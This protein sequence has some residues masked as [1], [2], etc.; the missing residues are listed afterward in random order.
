MKSLI[1]TRRIESAQ[2]DIPE[3]ADFIGKDVEIR[4]EE[5]RQPRNASGRLTALLGIM[6]RPDL[7]DTEMLERQEQIDLADMAK[8]VGDSEQTS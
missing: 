6:N 2:L 1:L 5:Q 3:L 4:I 8:L 7:I